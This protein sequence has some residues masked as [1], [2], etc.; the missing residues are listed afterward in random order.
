M[1][2]VL[3]L[4]AVA[5]LL[6]LLPFLFT[7]YMARKVEGML[8]PRGRFIDVPGAGLHLREFDGGDARA[9]AVLASLRRLPVRQG[10]PY[11]RLAG[12]GC[13]AFLLS[14]SPPFRCTAC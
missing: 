1:T 7:V 5:A 10:R 9:P 4:A 2:L 8:P 12:A 6:V 11:P 13:H 14:E 3:S